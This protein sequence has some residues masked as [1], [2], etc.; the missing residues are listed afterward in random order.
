MRNAK[1]IEEG[2]TVVYN[3]EECIVLD[4]WTRY[5]N[6]KVKGTNRYY[7]GVHISKIN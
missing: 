7:Q 1:R 3:G 5:V 2:S 4:S 6:V